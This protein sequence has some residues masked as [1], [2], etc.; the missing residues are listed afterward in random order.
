V[1][2]G[3]LGVFAVDTVDE[4][5]RGDAGVDWVSPQQ[6]AE[7]LTLLGLPSGSG[8]RDLVVAN[9]GDDEVR[10]VVR[11]V[12]DDSVFRPEGLDDVRVPPHSVT[13]VPLSAIIGQAVKDGAV[14]VQIEAA[15]PVTATLRSFVGGDLAHAVPLSPFAETT[16]AILPRGRSTVLLSS[17]S[18][19][20]AEVVARKRDGTDAVKSVDLVPG[21]TVSVK[22]P[23]DAVLVQV[24]PSSVAVRGAVVTLD[25]GAA[26]VGLRELVRTGLVPDLRPALP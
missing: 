13:R 12:T 19:G 25:G 6:P 22:L 18:V 23:D 11:I 5:G 24:T 9:D 3:R 26:V 20:A 8:S 14:G 2:R 10:A 1:T 21:R 15:Q 17:S 4:L 7:D 16:E